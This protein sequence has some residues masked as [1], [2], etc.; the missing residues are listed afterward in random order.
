[1]EPDRQK[2]RHEFKYILDP[3][4]LAELKARLGAVLE[5]D[6]HTGFSG[7]YEVRSLYFDDYDNSCYYANEDGQNLREKFR[8]RIYD[9]SDAT[10]HLELKQKQNGMTRK[11]S[12]PISR[13][14]TERLMKNQSLTWQDDWDPLMKRFYIWLNTQLG[15]PRVIVRYLGSLSY[16]RTGM[17]GSLW[18]WISLPAAGSKN[19]SKR[20]FPDGPCCPSA[21]T[22]WK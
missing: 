16:I 10:I 9:G 2:F 6:P 12:C 11:L 22:F 5:P 20:T 7:A 15:R 19:F 3:I 8:I 21:I 1:M 13:A 4:R 17:F 18:I 14:D